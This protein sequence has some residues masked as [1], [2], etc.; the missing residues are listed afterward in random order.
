MIHQCQI[1]EGSAAKFKAL[2]EE[3]YFDSPDRLKASLYGLTLTVKKPGSDQ[4]QD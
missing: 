4:E 3:F 2:L 1:S